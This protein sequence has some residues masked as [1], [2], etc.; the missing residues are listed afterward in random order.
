[1]AIYKETLEDELIRA[2]Y[3]F[4]NLFEVSLKYK[5]QDSLSLKENFI[6]E[7]IKRLSL[8]NDNI[9][10]NLSDVLQ[11]TNASTSI[12]VSAL[13]R[14]GFLKRTHSKEDRRV[15]HITLTSKALLF[16]S[17]QDEFRQRAIKEMSGTLNIVEKASLISTVKKLRVFLRKDMERIKKDKTPII[18]K[19]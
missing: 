17:K 3:E 16:L 13:E 1:M 7:V 19:D 2:F 12:A 5:T 8:T 11:I 15:Y 10:S 4:Y 18:T 14:K 9:T 6:I